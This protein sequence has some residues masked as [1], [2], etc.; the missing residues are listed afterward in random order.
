MSSQ[1]DSQ[2][3]QDSTM[4]LMQENVSEILYFAYGSNLSTEQM[5][6]RCPYSTPVGLAYL[7]GWKWIIN[8]R[9]YANVVQLPIDSDDDTPDAESNKQ[10]TDKGKE[11]ATNKV[12]EEEGVYG[13][14]YLVPAQDEERLDGYEGVPWAYQKFQVD[15]K[16]ATATGDEDETLRALVYVDEMRVD[17]DLPKE[18]YVDRME[19]GIEDAVENW[20]LD[21]EI[22][23]WSILSYQNQIRL[24]TTSSPSF[25]AWFARGGTSN[26]LV[27][28]RKD[29]PPESQWSQVLPSAMGS[30]DPYG[31]QLDGM[32]SGISS[33]SKVVILGPP[34]RDDVDVDFT[35]VQVGI[36]DGSLDMAGN[37]GNMSSLVGPAAWDS[38]LI[39]SED[40]GVETDQ[41][42][43]QWATVRFLNTNTDKVMSSKFR[44]EGEPLRYTHKGDYTM[45]GVPG[46]GSKIIMSFL[47]PAG[48]K[49]GKAL[50]TGNTVDTLTLSDGATV[51][52]SLVDVGN[53]GVFISTESLGLADHLSLTP[54]QVELNPQ[55]KDKLEEIRQAGA[56][57]MG[58]DPKIMSVPKIVLLFPSSCSSEVDIRCLALSMGQAHKAVPLTLG[59]CLGAAS[60]LKGTIASGLVGGKPKDTVT[61][62]HPSGRVDIGT[63]IRDAQ[64]YEMADPITS[65]PEPGHPYFPMDAVIPGYLPNTT[66]VF[67]LIAT[68]GAVV[69][70]VIGLAVWQTTRTRKPVRPID[71]FAVG[72]FALWYYLVY[73]H[74]LP[75]M[76]TLFA[77]LWKEYTLSDS[78]YLTHD[79]FTVS[80]EAITCLAWGPLSLLTV[81]G[82]LRDWHS[83]HVV[84]VIVCTAHV[85]GVALYYLTNWNESR[86]HGVAYS[87]PE[88][89]YFWVYY[90]GFNLPWAI[91]PLVLL[92]DSWS[93]VSKA[94]AAL[95]EKK[96]G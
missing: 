29:L 86:V 94:F 87:R 72:W 18:E 14:L 53:P 43:M 17:E 71:Q 59:L 93:Q 28:H 61:I 85:Y 20:G 80:V 6:Q 19:D 38:G 60:Q 70:A 4:T 13:L 11:K 58:L 63:V 2:Q 23:S 56:S 16:W 81:F 15:V 57:L 65:V 9:G 83:R 82:I 68:F 26:G 69:S 21:Q 91:V 52:A 88:T 42:G 74:Q 30:P 62:G 66:G 32:G 27:I 3:S 33:T 8:T 78:R 96:R 44:V 49:T 47:D 5:R 84:Q 7:K 67:E 34:S 46:T 89:L 36:Q 76:S 39:S 90:V 48:A 54:A 51:Q 12:E 55:L 92:R 35:F 79:I 77:Q 24:M 10:L 50:P 75:S 37:C 40:V 31:R 25:P 64:G 1:G 41:D 95:E 73:R 45:D 22:S